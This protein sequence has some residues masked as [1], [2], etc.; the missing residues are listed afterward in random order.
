MAGVAIWVL[1]KK[2][3]MR[4]ELAAELLSDGGPATWKGANRLGKAIHL[5]FYSCIGI[6]AVLLLVGYFIEAPR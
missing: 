3:I 2:W 5:I 4:S 1:P 6:L